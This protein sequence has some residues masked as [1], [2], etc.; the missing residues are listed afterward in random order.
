M[1]NL[2]LNR[3]D[4]ISLEDWAV[5]IARVLYVKLDAD[6]DGVLNVNDFS[7]IYT[8]NELTAIANQPISPKLLKFD[9]RA[10]KSDLS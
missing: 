7:Q 2:T 5:N 9:I 6:G 10:T 4:P 1:K 3:N 8:N